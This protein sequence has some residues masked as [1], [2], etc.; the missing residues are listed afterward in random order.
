V[1]G[2]E[3]TRV[4]IEVT[5]SQ[6]ILEPNLGHGRNYLNAAMCDVAVGFPGGHG[7][8]S[9]VAFA[10]ALG[11]PVVLVGEEWDT[12]FPPGEDRPARDALVASARK[13]VTGTGRTALDVLVD[14][15]YADVLV[16]P[17]RVE[18][19]GLDHPAGEVAATAR[20]LARAVGLR[21]DVPTLSD[22][23]DLTELAKQYRDWLA[24]FAHG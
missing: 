12:S 19:L 3:S 21:G 2:V 18:R 16:R 15:A 22:R 24:G 11:R 13:R 5:D 23:P 10:L 7:T 6:V 8:D 4:R 1:L 17:V 14:R 9:E 20:N